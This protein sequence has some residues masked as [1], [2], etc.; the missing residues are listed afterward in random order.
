MAKHF[1]I[2]NFKKTNLVVNIIKIVNR[3]NKPATES[4]I[5]K[6]YAD[7]NTPTRLFP[8]ENS[9]IWSTN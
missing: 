5:R 7:T 1:F 6:D 8:K 3:V 9:L 2:Y 4:Y